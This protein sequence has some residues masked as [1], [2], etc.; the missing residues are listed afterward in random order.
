MCIFSVRK[1]K[2]VWDLKKTFI[3]VYFQ[4]H[5]LDSVHL[6][7]PNYEHLRWERIQNEHKHYIN[8]NNSHNPGRR[9]RSGSDWFQSIPAFSW[10]QYSR[11]RIRWLGLA[12]FTWNRS[13]LTINRSRIRSQDFS[14]GFWV[15]S[16]R[17][18][19]ENDRLSAGFHRKS[20]EYCFWNHR[21]ENRKCST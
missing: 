6:E 19:P 14:V 18:Q 20:L 5:H 12:S 2:S 3:K 21:P 7:T 16:G 1:E 9:I 15:F 11:E 4:S 8:M 13:E 17:F 10:K